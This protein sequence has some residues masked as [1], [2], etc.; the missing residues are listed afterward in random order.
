MEV[1]VSSLSL[2]YQIDFGVD[3]LFKG[4]APSGIGPGVPRRLR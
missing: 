4:A 3:W 2:N 1:T